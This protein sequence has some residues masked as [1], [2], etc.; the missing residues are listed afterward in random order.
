VRHLSHL[1]PVLP[2]PTPRYVIA[3]Q[4]HIYGLARMFQITSRAGRDGLHVVRTAD[5]AY[6][7]LGLRS[8]QFEPLVDL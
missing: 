7:A 4:P 6:A 1:A 8:P 2:D 5:D 3:P